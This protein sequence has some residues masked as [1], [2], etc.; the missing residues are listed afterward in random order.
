M[1][2]MAQSTDST[3]KQGYLEIPQNLKIGYKSL[4][5]ATHADWARGV[6]RETRCRLCQA[7]PDEAEAKRSATQRG[8]DAL[9]GRLCGILDHA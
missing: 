4:L 2:E 6:V 1:G 9:M 7:I 3:V 8:H 5:M